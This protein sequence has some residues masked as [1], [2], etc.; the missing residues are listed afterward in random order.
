[1]AQHFELTAAEA[2]LLAAVLDEIIPR[3]SDGKMPGAGEIGLVDDI[4]RALQ[5]HPAPAPVISQAL[6]VL[7]QMT[8]ERGWQDVDLIG[9]ADRLALLQELE[10]REPAFVPTLMFLSYGLYYQHP[11]VLQALGR[12]ARPPHPA[13]YEMVPNDLTLLD[14]VRRRGKMFR[15]A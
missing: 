14:P 13:G 3:S 2:R 5:Q 1:M 15:D 11:R 7:A 9:K 12:E 4:E 6:A 8:R 10:V